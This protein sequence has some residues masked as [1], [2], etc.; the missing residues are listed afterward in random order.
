MK[1]VDRIGG[2]I[3]F[4][5]G[6]LILIYSLRYPI[7]SLEMPKAGFFPLVISILLVLLSGSILVL[8]FLR[9]ERDVSKS[10]LFLSNRAAKRIAYALGSLLAFGFVLPL[11]GFAPSVFLFIFFLSL[12]VAEYRLSWSLLFSILT[13]IV[14]YFTFQTLLRILMPSGIFGI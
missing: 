5:F 10:S 11:I 12:F 14:F 1:K 2:S 4:L 6:L 9:N 7:G 3:L 8:S 13:A